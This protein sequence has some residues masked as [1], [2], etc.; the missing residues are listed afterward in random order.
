MW[1]T[2]RWRLV[3]VV[4]LLFALPVLSFGQIK[5]LM[6]GGFS[7]AYQELLPEFEKATGITI[8]TLRGPSQGAGPDAAGPELCLWN[9]MVN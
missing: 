7:P 4:G 5:I 9:R 1:T 2:T 8:T 3:L 6:S